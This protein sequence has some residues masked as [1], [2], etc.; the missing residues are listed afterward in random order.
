MERK[1][2]PM[3]IALVLAVVFVLAV[4]FGAKFVYNKAASAP[5]VVTDLG[6]EEASSAECQSFVDAL[7]DKVG[8]FSRVP[9][10]EPVPA[11]AA[12]YTHGLEDELT[13]RCGVPSPDYASQA[14]HVTENSSAQWLRVS[15]NSGNATWFTLNTSPAIAVTAPESSNAKKVTGGLDEAIATLNHTESDLPATPLA[16]LGSASD[17]QSDAC[18]SL[19][20]PEN[21]GDHTLPARPASPTDSWLYTSDTR[22]PIEVRCGVEMSPEYGAGAR[23][24]QLDGRPW[25]TDSSG[26]RW[27]SLGTPTVAIFAPLDLAENVLADVSRQIGPADEANEPA[28][29]QPAGQPAQ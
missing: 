20:L 26:L 22:N 14:D 13:I 19:D 7:P 3:V 28:Q 29:D 5:T 15:D 1:N 18:T 12:A 21:Y 11:G 10:A 8:G 16:R 25:F 23:L 4:I 17:D 2:T 9:I 27:W 6:Y 24:T